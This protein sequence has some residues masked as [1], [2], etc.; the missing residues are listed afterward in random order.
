MNG[1]TRIDRETAIM[2]ADIAGRNV[3][4][5]EQVDNYR[6]VLKTDGIDENMIREIRG[7]VSGKL[8][9]RLL[10]IWRTSECIAFIVGY[11]EPDENLISLEAGKT[12]D[13]K[14]GDVYCHRLEEV[15]AV[16]V[17]RDTFDRLLRFTGGGHMVTQVGGDC[18]YNTILANGTILCVPEGWWV[19]REESGRFV[20]Y[21]PAT[22]RRNYEPKD[23]PGDLVTEEF[24]E[25]RLDELYGTDI[26]SRF[27]KLS[28]E[29]WELA[30]ACR[31][32]VLRGSATEKEREH[33]IDELGDVEIVLM[34]IASLL[35]TSPGEC[36]R[37]AFEKIEKRQE[38]PDYMREHP[39][40]G[41]LPF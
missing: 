4:I 35:G 29:Y 8:G 6:I 11:G 26:T 37:R 1:L 38:D 17:A 15:R 12:P 32:L 7:A 36:I 13:P 40:Y 2:I 20:K 28:E 27:R 33:I 18:E 23:A 16:K 31:P 5:D 19:V 39:R 24:I 25:G 21:D 41:D 34:H 14:A 10:R 9:D 30:E 22:F 3:S